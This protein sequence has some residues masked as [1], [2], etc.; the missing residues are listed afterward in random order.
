MP[1]MTRILKP[2]KF[3][4]TELGKLIAKRTAPL[5]WTSEGPSGALEEVERQYYVDLAQQILDEMREE[6]IIG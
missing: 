6:G 3:N 5:P 4:S 2:E 1:L